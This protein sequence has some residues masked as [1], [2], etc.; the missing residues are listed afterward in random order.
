[1]TLN[2]LP[3]DMDGHLSKGTTVRGKQELTALL[4]RWLSASAAAT[5]GDVGTYG[6]SACVVIE[7][8]GTTAVLNADTKRSAVEAYIEQVRLLGADMSWGVIANQKGR[9][10]KVVFHD[11]RAT[12]GWYCYLTEP[13]D[14]PGTL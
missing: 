5:I 2:K 10:N 4:G 9:F 14:A 6:G 3:L 7:L 8:G 11:G 1:M 13:L 12:F